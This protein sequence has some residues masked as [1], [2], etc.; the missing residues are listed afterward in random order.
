MGDFAPQSRSM[1]ERI[2]LE[3]EYYEDRSRPSEHIFVGGIPD[4]RYLSELAV[5][6]RPREVFDE[7]LD[8]LVEVPGFQVQLTGSRRALFELGRYFVALSRLKTSDPDYHDHVD[9][10]ALA[11]VDGEK[12]CEL[13]FR[14]PREPSG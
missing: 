7:D 14:G 8:D 2:E 10:E 4:P 6:V 3:L 9:A 12:P 1:K 13:I 11:R 5:W